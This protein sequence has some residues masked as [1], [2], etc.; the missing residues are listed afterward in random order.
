MSKV[1]ILRA[2]KL[3][4]KMNITNKRAAQRTAES[5]QINGVFGLKIERLLV[6]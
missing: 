1:D 2:K 5:G 4:D 3:R 6:L